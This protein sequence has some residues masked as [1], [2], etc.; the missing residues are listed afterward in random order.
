MILLMP[1][2]QLH[3][4]EKMN[5]FFSLKNHKFQEKIVLI[6]KKSTYSVT[7]KILIACNFGQKK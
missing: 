4:I 5:N 7:L 1:N 6:E 2:C 3:L